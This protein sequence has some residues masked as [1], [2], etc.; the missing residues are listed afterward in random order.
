MY[1]CESTSK[2]KFLQLSYRDLRQ[3]TGIQISNWSKWFN[4]TMS[5]TLDTLR[6]IANDLDMPLLELIE[7]FEERRS[8]TIQRS[9][10]IE[11]A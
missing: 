3:R 1:V 10:E 8:R 4:G 9:K 6:R 11:S 2:E 7:A 5:P